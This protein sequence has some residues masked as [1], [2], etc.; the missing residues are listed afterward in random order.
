[1]GLGEV[2]RWGEEINPT[3]SLG[4]QTS[5]VLKINPTSRAQGPFMAKSLKVMIGCQYW[6]LIIQLVQIQID[7]NPYQITSIYLSDIIKG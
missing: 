7:S 6:I 4:K 2:S 3:L 1:M 5:G